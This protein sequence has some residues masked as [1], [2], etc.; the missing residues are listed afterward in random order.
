LARLFRVKP[1][2]DYLCLTISRKSAR[3]EL[4]V[5]LRDWR[6][7]G[8]RDVVV[9]KERNIVFARVGA[10]NCKST[11]VRSHEIWTVETDK[12]AAGLSLKE[13]AFAAEVMTVIEHGKRGQLSIIRL[14]QERGAASS[15]HKVVEAIRLVL[16]TRSI[17]VEDKQKAKM[18]IKTL[19]A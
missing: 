18:M 14:T 8:M 1:V 16:E 7:H 15:F 19:N 13:V 12:E 11:L 4:A 5:L 17:V 9:D 3:Q 10:N 6:R 2:Q